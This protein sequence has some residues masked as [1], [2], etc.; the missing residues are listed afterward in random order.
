MAST[1]P[2]AWRGAKPFSHR[3][4]EHL[5]AGSVPVDSGFDPADKAVAGDD[6]EHVIAPPA[7]L[8]AGRSPPTRSRSRTGSQGERCPLDGYERAELDQLLAQFVVPRPLRGRIRRGDAVER[9]AGAAG[10]EQ[11]VSAVPRQELVPEPFSL[12]HLLREQLGREQPVE[13]VVVPAIAAAPR[14]VDH[15]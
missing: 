5:H 11:A 4:I 7:L 13:E 8:P 15:T 2:L 10:A 9:A 3:D 12:R 14:E 6:R 1:N